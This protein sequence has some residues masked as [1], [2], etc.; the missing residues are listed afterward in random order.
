MKAKDLFGL[1]AAAVT[2]LAAAGVTHACGLWG[3]VGNYTVPWFCGALAVAV[4][5]LAVTALLAGTS[6]VDIPAGAKREG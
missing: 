6:P 3:F 4:L 1:I 2:L 5:I